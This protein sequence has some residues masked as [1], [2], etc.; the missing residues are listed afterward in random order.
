MRLRFFTFL[1]V[2]FGGLLVVDFGIWGGFGVDLWGVAVWCL[3]WVWAT[4]TFGWWISWC[5][6]FGGLGDLVAVSYFVCWIGTCW[7]GL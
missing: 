5:R 2:C 4:L 7:F 1:L 3:F 6:G